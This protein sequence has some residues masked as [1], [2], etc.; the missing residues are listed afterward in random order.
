VPVI[1]ADAELETGEVVIVNVAEEAPTGTVT[2]AGTTALEL[3]EVSLTVTAL[4]ATGPVSVIVA[5]EALP[6]ITDAGDR[7]IA[8]RFAA[9]T[10]SAVVKTVEP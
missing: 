6:P 1:V 10:V 7:V 2:P 3:F 4:P 5:M 9:V 8:E